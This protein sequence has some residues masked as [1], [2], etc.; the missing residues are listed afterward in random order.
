METNNWDTLPWHRRPGV[1]WMYP[2]VVI[3]ALNLLMPSGP[4]AEELVR[5]ACV[6][7]ESGSPGTNASVPIPAP[8][9][10]TTPLPP[11]VWGL[12]CEL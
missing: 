4:A 5:L 8:L 10:P 2:F 7:V 6:V 3:L 12:T 9:P 1:A 11:L